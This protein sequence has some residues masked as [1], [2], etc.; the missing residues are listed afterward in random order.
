MNKTPSKSQKTQSSPHKTPKSKSP[1]K[2]EPQSDTKTPMHINLNTFRVNSI[3][4]T[5]SPIEHLFSIPKLNLLALCRSNNSIELWTTNSWIQLLKI[6]GL[7]SLQTR[8]IFLYLK[9]NEDEYNNIL[10]KIRLFTCGLNGYLVEWS[11]INSMPKFTYKNPGG[12][13]WDIQFNEKICLIASND[14]TP[15]AV[16]IKKNSDPYLIKQYAKS[17]SRVLSICWENNSKKNKSRIFYTGHSNGTICKWNFETGQTLLTLSNPSAEK[18]VLMWSLCSINSKFLLCGDSTGKLLVYD[19]N[20]GVLVKEFKEHTGDILTIISNNNLNEP[21]VYY[22]GIDSLICSV[23]LNLKN[24]EWILTSSFRGQ[25]HDINSLCLLNENYLLGGGITTD[26]C[27]Y[28]LY[29]GNMFQKYDSKINTNVKRHISPFE[30]KQN[31]YHTDFVDSSKKNVLILHKKDEHCDL[32]NVNL[33]NNSS[34]YLAKLIRKKK[35]DAYLLSANISRTGKYISFSYDENTI[36]FKYNYENN[37]IKKLHEFKLQSNFIFFNKEETKLFLIS[38]KESKINIYDN[39][40]FE[41]IKSISLSSEDLIL[42]CDFDY[43]TNDIAFSTFSKQVYYVNTMKAEI[44][45]IPHPDSFVTKIKFN[46]KNKTVIL[47]DENNLIYI[48]ELSTF[49]FNKWTI[50]RI[51]KNDYPENYL[52]W[53]NK[54]FGVTIISKNVFLLYT[55]YNYIKVDMTKQLPKESMIEKNKMDKYVKSDWEKIIKEFH[56]KVFDEEYKGKVFSKIRKDIFGNTLD[57]NKINTNFDNDNFKITSKFNSIML[58]DMLDNETMLVIENDWNKI[59][60]TFPGG[61]VK[62]NYGH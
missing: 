52:K 15:R 3:E 18:D 58:M 27:I 46:P 37:E 1:K 36:L 40:T 19:I 13:I 56:E 42:T 28:H 50:N 54:I 14:G 8:R 2:E 44:H 45:S 6:P 9:K 57:K 24:N 53:Y 12:C 21:C 38:Q 55:D 11:L 7:K 59:I 48:I 23:K 33:N 61:L 51:E 31:Y 16:K 60:K 30:H 62:P 29:N 43:Q 26:I 49:K 5:P 20:F 35:D 4:N 34:T 22:T 39:N 25:S 47:I 10:D 32:W 41:L 17:D